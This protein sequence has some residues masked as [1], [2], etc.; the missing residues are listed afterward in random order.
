MQDSSWCKYRVLLGKPGAGKSQVLIRAIHE[1]IQTEMAVLLAAPVAL[2]AQS[3]RDIFG[4]DLQCDTL[5]A[6][7]HIPIDVDQSVDFNFSLNKSD[8]VVIDEASLVSTASFNIVAATLNRLNCRP[9]VV[10]AGDK[11]QQ[12]PLQTVQGRVSATVSILNDDTF[13]NHNAVKH[14]LLKQFRIL[15]KDHEDFVE[16]IRY[17]Q[18]TQRQLDDF[19]QN[20]VIYPR[21]PLQD[22]QLY[23]AFSQ[24]SDTLIMTVSRFASQRINRVVCEKLFAEKEP[25]SK[26]PC[27]NVFG[28]DCLLPYKGMRVVITENR[29]KAA[30][31]VNG[32]HAKIVNSQG[33]TILLEFP[34]SQKAFVHPVTHH[35]EE[36]R[37]I[38]TYPFAPA[39]STTIC[40]CQ[41]QNILKHLIWLDCPIVPPGIAYVALSRVRRKSDLSVMQPMEIAQVTPV[42]A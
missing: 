40:K 1:A 15:D 19:Q 31:I 41:G 4:P 10:I 29:D 5:H 30:R 34:D 17:L 8:M 23:K 7:F 22:E 25:L 26:V 3:Y 35:V 27:S 36:Q 21:G 16:M 20:L 12:Q 28:Q 11:R 37:D 39:Y 6:A 13:T 24:Q 42:N 18:P 2:L 9:V 14:S 33:N 32:Q 38:T